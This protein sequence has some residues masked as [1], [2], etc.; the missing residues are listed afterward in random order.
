MNVRWPFIF[1]LAA[2]ISLSILWSGLAAYR[3]A[4]L[5]WLELQHAKARMIEL[6][7][8]IFELREIVYEQQQDCKARGKR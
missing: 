3:R 5:T 8:L 7:P 6:E 2:A 1:G 4:S